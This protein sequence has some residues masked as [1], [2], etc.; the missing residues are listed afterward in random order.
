MTVIILILLIVPLSVLGW[1]F[2]VDVLARLRKREQTREVCRSDVRFTVLVPAH[3]EEACIAGILESLRRQTYGRFNTYVIADCC[4]DGTR[5]IVSRYPEIRIID[6][7]VPSTSKGDALH[8]AIRELGEKLGDAVVILDADCTVNPTFLE[9]MNKQ[10]RTGSAAVMADTDILNPHDSTV[11]GWYTVYWKMVSEMSRRAHAKMG[12]SCNL[13]GSGMSFRREYLRETVTI[14]EDVEYFMALAG[15]GTRIDYAGGAKVFQEQPTTLK[16]LLRQL[17]RWM[18]GVRAVNKRYRRAYLRSMFRDFTL[19]KLDAF[20]TSQ[21]CSAYGL[22]TILI[23]LD[24]L[25]GFFFPPAAAAA[26]GTLLLVYLT[27]LAIGITVT[28]RCKL[29]GRIRGAVIPTYF[30]FLIAMGFTYVYAIIFP[31]DTWMKVD[32]AKRNE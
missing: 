17:Y 14:T 27:S 16:D 28:R 29:R 23:L 7:T 31:G 12:L 1:G 24:A 11:T 15:D 25:A 6:K 4:T 26:A 21:T 19:L 10:Y 22:L 3:N 8:Y 20:M 13:C 18:N 5:E 30:F 32:R 2:A 9:E